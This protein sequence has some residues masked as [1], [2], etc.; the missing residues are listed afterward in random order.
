MEL[1]NHTMGLL[2]R[3]LDFREA[4]QQ[5][6]TANIANEETPGYHAKDLVFVD[7]LAG[8]MRGQRPVT[9]FV[10]HVNHIGTTGSPIEQ[11][12]GH[13][14]TLPAGELPLDHNSVNVE[15]ELA[16]LSDNSGKFSGAASI[17][18]LQF[19]RLIAA[20]RDTV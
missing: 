12:R 2:V 7:A 15:L 20:I 11:T 16:K 10:S 3:V 9:P 4:R 18:A 13:M 14:I 1:F 5:V 6:I 17:L 19:R 8:A